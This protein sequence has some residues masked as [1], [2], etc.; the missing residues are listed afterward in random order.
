[1]KFQVIG[2]YSR[3]TRRKVLSSFLNAAIT[4][5]E[6]MEPPFQSKVPLE[7]MKLEELTSLQ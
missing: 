6:S 1:M 5:S 2:A 3:H 4:E 7:S